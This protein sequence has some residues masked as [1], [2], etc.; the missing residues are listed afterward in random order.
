MRPGL[1]VAVTV[2]SCL[3]AAAVR[4]RV[5]RF[6]VLIGNNQGVAAD[7]P[8]RYAEDDATRMYDVLRQLG[9]FPA[10][11]TILLRG[12]SVDEVRE[13]L[14]A[15]NERIREL[16]EEPGAQA[17]LVVYYSGHADSAA[18]R[19]A[20]GRLDLQELRRHARGSAADFR[21]VVVDAC[22]SGALTR[23]KGSRRAAP[24]SLLEDGSRANPPPLPGS[25]FAFLTA[26]SAHEDAQE[27]DELKGA[28]FTHALVSGLLGAA[29]ADGDGAVVLDEAYRYAYESTLRATSRTFAGTQ[30]PTFHYQIRGRGRLSLTRPAAHRRGRATVE[31][32]GGYGYLF[33]R[34][35]ENGPVVAELEAGSQNRRMSLSPG[36]YFVRARG[37]DVFYE[38]AFIAGP[39]SLRL[40]APEDLRRID[41][42]RLVRKGAVER[43][44]A[45]GPEV[46]LHVRSPLPNE[47]TACIGGFI[48]YA[49][50]LSR[51]SVRARV[52][53]CRSSLRADGVRA[54]VAAHDV[55][56]S[57][58][59]AWDLGRVTW[60][61]GAG[62]GMSLLEQAFS[63]R[64]NAPDQLASAPF[65][66]AGLTA[67]LHL[68]AGFH[69][70]L[71]VDAQAHLLRVID[72]D[73]AGRLL[74]GMGLRS[75][76]SLGK[77][78]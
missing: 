18:L 45:H 52:G 55:E 37:P 60:D 50:E 4:A 57:V 39:G 17:V 20:G 43:Q 5:E 16:R 65:A 13:A 46:G 38:G 74:P 41:Y 8:L 10:H 53:T 14:L 62:L 35:D 59:H 22:R 29:D 42:A 70:A 66:T 31:L 78:F 71:T 44:L 7:A 48:G 21:L 11:Q 61:L 47:S 12:R 32:P 64:V 3:L 58:R 23:V 26:T 27:S 9:D 1:F 68:P 24:F 19:L 6:A 34:G 28:F 49:L 25:G 76:L 69:V 33:M 77:D 56:L 51:F 36:P 67:R 73:P 15:I 63:G 72:D 30:H 40:I 75:G 54:E 2:I